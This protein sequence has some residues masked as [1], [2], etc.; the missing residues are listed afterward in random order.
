MRSRLRDGQS[1]EEIA[2][3]LNQRGIAAFVL[4]Y[5]LAKAKDSTYTL[6]KEV[7]ADAA[8]ALRL[9]RSRAKEWNFDPAKLGFIGTA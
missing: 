2:D 1:D 7:Y 9:V 4:K 8:R 6:P 5:R 3:W